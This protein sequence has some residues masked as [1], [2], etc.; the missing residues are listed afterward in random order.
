MPYTHLN[1]LMQ[2]KIILICFL[3]IVI[4]A[5]PS[6]GQE[7]PIAAQTG[8]RKGILSA[9]MNPAEINNLNRP[10]DVHL[11]SVQGGISNN[12][13]S[14]REFVDSDGKFIDRAFRNNNGTFS[15][16]TSASVIGPGVGVKLGKWS[17][18]FSSMLTAN[19]SFNELDGKFGR[20]LTDEDFSGEF[21]EI[22]LASSNSQRLFANSHLE[23]G[24]LGGYE[25]WSDQWSKFSVGANL[26]LLFPGNFT[27]FSL[28]DFRGTII[29][30]G[31]EISLTNAQGSL[32]LSYDQNLINTTNFNPSLNSL[33]ANALNGVGLDLG[34]N[35]QLSNDGG[36]WLN[37]GLSVQNI[38]SMR[39]GSGQTFNTYQIAIPASESFR[40]DLLET[41]LNDLENQLLESDFFTKQVDRN[42]ISTQ[43]PTSIAI[44]ADVQL[45]EKIMVSAY[46]K[47]FIRDAE[48][49]LQL[50][51][52]DMA[53]VIP[54]L[55]LGNFE[56]Y[57][58][59]IFMQHAGVAG[60]LGLRYGGFYLGS[61]S[62]LTGYFGNSKQA[63]FHIG[64]SLGFG[65]H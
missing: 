38:G 59:W 31:S 24:F 6:F 16:M 34:V 12:S 57:S 29:Q 14:F 56:V 8:P 32:N 27:H 45:S 5:I 4:L 18:G 1:L 13:F 50:N 22:S 53:V 42:G 20:Y 63:D 55:V 46:G 39:F 21:I 28:N 15:G 7:M 26:K 35:Y 58:P 62:L 19:A 48:A 36:V 30:N 3:L 33:T 41:D 52:L 49:N 25:L 60:G 9:M 61:H 11:F 23:I 65:N 2:S 54:R 43:L 44:N 64:L 37:T 51:A 17:V 40:L 10:I 47:K